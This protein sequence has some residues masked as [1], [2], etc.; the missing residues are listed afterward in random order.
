MATLQ[1]IQQLITEARLATALDE[2]W[3]W[4]QENGNPE[5]QTL[6]ATWKG[7][8][9]A[10]EER[11]STRVISTQEQ[12]QETAIITQGVLTFVSRIMDAPPPD[13]PAIHD[14]HSYT[15]DRNEQE[16]IFKSEFATRDA[17]PSR[18]QFYYL[19]G[20]DLQLHTGMVQRIAY[21]LEGRLYDYLNPDLPPACQTEFVDV[22]FEGDPP[23]EDYTIEMLARLF[24]AFGLQPN[25][26]APLRERTLND[27]LQQ[28]PRIRELG[29][30]D[31]ICVCIHINEYFWYPDATPEAVIWFINDFCGKPTPPDKPRL[32]FFFAVEY[33]ETNISLKQELLAAVGQNPQITALPELN[34][35]TLVDI[36]K[37][38]VAYKNI[39]PDPRDRKAI[40]QTHFG[41]DSEYYMIDVQEKLLKIIT[42]HNNQRLLS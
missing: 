25:Q 32:L 3:T 11:A 40:V 33:D 8:Y 16:K 18:V 9:R 26:F 37:W 41:T 13:R 1:Q 19:Y 29:G 12:L 6:V 38:F 14:Y 42:D 20:G 22:P 39:A 31:Y 28:S 35:V 34:M 7:N 10:I 36:N 23:T 21:N 17:T 4:A 30:Q 2:L 24:S 5:Q 15:C 27:I